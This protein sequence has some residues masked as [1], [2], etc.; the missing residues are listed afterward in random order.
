[1]EAIVQI[2]ARTPWWVLPLFAFLVS[3]GI[4]ALNPAEVSLA[5]LAVIPSVFMIWGLAGLNER[6]GPGFSTFI[7]WL[8]ALAIGAAVGAAI[9]RGAA[10][11]ADRTR[12][13]VYRSADFT[14][15]PLIL[16]AFCSKYVLAVTAGISPE[17]PGSLGFCIADVG[18]SGLFAGVFIGKF[19]RYLQV[20]LA[21]PSARLDQ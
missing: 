17:I 21:K 18:M 2:L 3:R 13:V 11:K 1:M 6:Y 16:I 7:L 4:R 14:V 19:T 20:Y 12:G 10:L 15:L 9:L 8:A 5:Q